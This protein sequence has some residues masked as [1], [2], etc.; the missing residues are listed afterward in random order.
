PECAPGPVRRQRVLDHP[1]DYC[2]R[3]FLLGT[4]AAVLAVFVNLVYPF[5]FKARWS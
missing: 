2:V 1:D 3:Y 5:L 4:L